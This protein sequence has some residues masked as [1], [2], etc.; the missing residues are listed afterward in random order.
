MHSLSSH[1]C[2]HS[3]EAYHSICIRPMASHITCMWE[4]RHD[5]SVFLF[6]I[7]RRWSCH[8]CTWLSKIELLRYLCIICMVF[9]PC[10]C[11]LHLGWCTPWGRGCSWRWRSHYWCTCLLHLLALVVHGLYMSTN[12]KN[13]SPSPRFSI[14]NIRRSKPCPFTCTHGRLRTDTDASH[15]GAHAHAGNSLCWWIFYVNLIGL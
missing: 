1:T 15:D 6:L 14:T 11:L 12:L 7:I 8:S 5:A 13:S 4:L 10:Q 3:D 9:F 2:P